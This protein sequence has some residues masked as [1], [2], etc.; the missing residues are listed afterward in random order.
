MQCPF[1]NNLSSRAYKPVNLI[2]IFSKLI[3]FKEQ[4]Q[5]AQEHTFQSRKEF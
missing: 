5:Q 3:E 1:L 2:S 4:N